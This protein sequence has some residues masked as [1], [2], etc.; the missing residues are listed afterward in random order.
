VRSLVVAGLLG[1]AAAGPVA[2]A[3]I[4]D[5]AKVDVCKVVPGEDVA[6]ALGK[7]LKK[8]RP[9]TTETTSRCVYLLAPPGKPDESVP[10]VVLW[11]YTAEDYDALAKVT[12]ATTE[13]VEGLGDA[14]MRFK[15]PGDG[16]FKLRVVKRGQFS[17]E[18]VAA[19]PASSRKLAG[20]A[21]ACFSK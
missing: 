2:A 13:P 14:A 20:L 19:D 5:P 9:M 21:L 6:A 16:L 4:P 10:G 3:T 12:E 17:L 15:D 8:A 11:L 7:T 18:A 1:A